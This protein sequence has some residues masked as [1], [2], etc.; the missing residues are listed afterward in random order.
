MNSSI[1]IRRATLLAIASV[2]TAVACTSG[3][4]QGAVGG[5]GPG[6]GFSL[7][8]SPDQPNPSTLTVSTAEESSSNDLIT[9]RVDVTA[10]NDVFAALFE[11]S[12]PSPQVEFVSW[13]AGSLLESGGQQVAYFVDESQAGLVAVDIARLGG[14]GVSVGS[15]PVP[16][17]FLTYRVGQPGTYGLSFQN[18]QLLDD[19]PPQP[20]VIGGMNWFEGTILAQ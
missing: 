6:T 5:P 19:G 13:S 18:Q 2:L 17:I 12:H 20:Q 15:T 16:V 10:T 4:G 11:V 14:N 8:F 3:G 1:T 9:I 7:N